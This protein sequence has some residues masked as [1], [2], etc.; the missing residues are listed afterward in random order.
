M[1]W[2]VLASTSPYRTA[3]AVEE[4]L[5]HDNLKEATV[6]LQELID[7][8]ARSDKRALKSHLVRLMTHIIKWHSQPER[9]SRSWRATIRSSRREIAGIQEET[10]SLTRVVI[11]EMWEDC[12]ETAKEEAEGDMNQEPRVARL[13][14]AE[15]FDHAYD[16]E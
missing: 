15:V 5:R 6:G 9:R 4:A 7:A 11:E 1:N 8:L 16:L 12:F 14:W 2:Q 13:S 3:V 10:P